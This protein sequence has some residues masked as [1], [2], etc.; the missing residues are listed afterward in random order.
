MEE[1]ILFDA[2]FR[3]VRAKR[4]ERKETAVLTIEKLALPGAGRSLNQLASGLL[5]GRESSANNLQP[6]TLDGALKGSMNQKQQK[7]LGFGAAV[8]S[9]S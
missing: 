8:A 2:C 1:Q 6:G 7:C 3:F 9:L 5:A 4:Q